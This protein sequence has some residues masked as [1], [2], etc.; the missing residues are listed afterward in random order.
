[1]PLGKYPSVTTV[2]MRSRDFNVGAEARDTP[3][4]RQR[5]KPLTVPE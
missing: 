5:S 4:W 1:M 3:A 2:K